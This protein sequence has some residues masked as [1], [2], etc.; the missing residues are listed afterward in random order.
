MAFAQKSAQNFLLIDNDIRDNN[1]KQCYLLYGEEIYLVLQYKQ[2][3][4]KAFGVDEDSGMNTAYF[5]GKDINTDELISLAGTMP[6]FAD[7]RTIIISDSGFFKSSQDKLCDFFKNELPDTTRFIFVESEVDKR[8]RMY[9]AVKERGESVEM[10]RLD[11]AMLRKWIAKTLRAE[12][13]NMEPAVLANF[14]QKTGNDM[15]N[16]ST[17]LEKLICYCYGKG[18]ITDDDVEEIVTEQLQDRI[19][20]MIEA[21]NMKQKEKAL[22]LYYD[23]LALKTAPIIILSLISQNFSSMLAVKELKNKGYAKQDIAAKLGIEPRQIWR[24]D[25]L[26][27]QCSS[28]DIQSIENAFRECIEYDEKVKKGLIADRIAVEIIIIKYSQK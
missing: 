7:Y 13:K 9:K 14:L 27:T 16:I 23:L 24:V 5:S 25:K 22:H 28:Y 1:L 6:F 2:K 26:L 20:N 10:T 17:E 3:L 8:S 12:G 18:Q 4:L 15:S 21:I 11:E 19:F